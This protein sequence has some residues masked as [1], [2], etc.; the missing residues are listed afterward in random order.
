ML[1]N[2][3]FFGAPTIAV[4]AQD[5]SL[6]PADA[7][8]VGMWLQTF[9]LA[10]TE[11]GLGTCMEISVAGYPEVLRRGF[12]IPEELDVFCGVAIGW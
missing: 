10:L 6:S 12:G 11:R 8:C 4:V 9:V 1:R 2:Y 7:M 3:E 5:R